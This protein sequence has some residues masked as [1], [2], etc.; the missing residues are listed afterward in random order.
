MLRDFGKLAFIVLTLMALSA[1]TCHAQEE[2]AESFTQISPSSSMAV[3]YDI[4][5]FY[6]VEPSGIVP[7]YNNS[8][9]SHL[10]MDSV[11]HAIGFSFDATLSN[12]PVIT[13]GAGISAGKEIYKVTTSWTGGHP[14]M[15]AYR[16]IPDIHIGID[17]RLIFVKGGLSYAILLGGTPFLPEDPMYSGFGLDCLNPATLYLYWEIGFRVWRFCFALGAR[18]YMAEPFDIERMTYYNRYQ[19]RSASLGGQE[20]FLKIGINLFSNYL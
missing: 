1:A 2:K 13:V 11:R 7:I 12:F 10:Y 8:Q 19:Y 17:G 18:N 20:L 5:A 3:L 15:S 16:L 9:Y 6:S 14:Q 4:T